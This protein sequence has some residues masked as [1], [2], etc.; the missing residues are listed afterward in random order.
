MRRVSLGD[1]PYCGSSEV[2]ASGPRKPGERVYAVFLLKLAK[3][4][5]CMHRHL[6]LPFFPAVQRPETPTES[7]ISKEHSMS[8]PVYLPTCHIC[9]KPVKL[10]MAKTD[11][12]GRTVH[13]GCYLLTVMARRYPVPPK[14]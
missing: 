7:H 9:N 5:V 12:S 14:A 8:S 2:Y 3:C 10:E 4:E 1:C 11:E 13:E 6:R